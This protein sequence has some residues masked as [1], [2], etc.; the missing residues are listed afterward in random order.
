MEFKHKRVHFIGIGGISMSALAKL[1]ELDG[2]IIS[3]SDIKTHDAKNI[4]SEIDLVVINGAIADDN[5]ELLRAK[6]LNLQ[7]IDRGKLL[8]L[9]E[10]RYTN[11][12]AIAGTH[13]K[14]TV[15]AMVGTVLCAG[16]LNPT[17]HSGAETTQ[18]PSNGTDGV[19]SIGGL[20]LGGTEFFVTEACEFKQSFLHLSPTIAVITNIDADHLDCYHDFNDLV[21]CFARFANSARDAVFFGEMCCCEL[22]PVTPCNEYAP[23]K[24][25]FTVE[26]TEIRL[27]VVGKHNVSNAVLAV[28]VGRHFGIPMPVIKD[29]LENFKGV[30]RRFQK[31]SS[32]K[33]D[34]K[35]QTCNLNPRKPQRPPLKTPPKAHTN[36]NA[37]AAPTP[38]FR[39]PNPAVSTSDFDPKHAAPTP[40]FRSNP[41]VSTAKSCD[42]IVDYAHHPTEIETTIATAT[43]LYGKGNFLIVFQP[44]TYTRTKLLFAEFT[45][46]LCKCDY[47]LYKTFSAREKPIKGGTARDLARAVSKELQGKKTH[48][49]KGIS[50]V[51]YFA[52]AETLRHFLTRAASKYDAIILTGAGDINRFAEVQYHC[53]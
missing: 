7:I 4:Y 1:V 19:I 8:A 50:G 24:Y 10:A 32:L 11:R 42:I 12:I 47:V 13:G 53:R 31:I 28:K 16:G 39:T 3:G 48:K 27:G 23:A 37:K 35:T 9:I 26:G 34:P 38:V 43:S 41:A 51:R 17:V 6:E 21:A 36:P 40:N 44:H 30:S 20:T 18:S 46:V 25:S 14:S 45:R 52:G 2:A 22:C 5:P 49:T 29:A 15:T 33:S